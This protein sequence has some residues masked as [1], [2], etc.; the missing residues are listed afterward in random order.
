VARGLGFTAR[1]GQDQL[2]RPPPVTIDRRRK[3]DSTMVAS[4]SIWTW[5]TSSTPL[6]TMSISPPAR[7][8]SSRLSTS[9]LFGRK[10][11]HPPV[12]PSSVADGPGFYATRWEVN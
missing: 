7:I 10:A 9:D 11:V 3:R 6:R 1:R 2:H 5:S 4:A 8:A 12:A